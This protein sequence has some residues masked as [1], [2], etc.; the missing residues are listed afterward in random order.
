MELRRRTGG[1]SLLREVASPVIAVAFTAL[2][3]AGLFALLGKPPLSALH[4]YFIEPLSD[5]W[6]LHELAVKA[7]PLILIAVGLSACYRANVWNIGAEGQLVAGAIAGSAIPVLFPAATGPWLMPAMIVMAMAGGAAW[8]SIPAVL[9]NRFGASEILVSL[10]LVYVA[11]LLL[12]YLVRGPWRNPEGYNFPETRQ[13]PPSARI[14]EL[15]SAGDWGGRANWGIVIA[16]AI[17]VL[18]W[19]LLSRTLKGFE[20]SVSG[21]S[22]RA[23]R[24]AGFDARATA[25]FVFLFSG[26]LAGLAGM[27]EV[28]GAIG[29]LRPSISPGYGF[30]AIIV[31]F[32]GRLNPLAVILAGLLLALTYLGGEAA[33]MSLGLSDRTT[34]VFQGVLL[35]SVLA[36]ETLVRY[37]IR[38]VRNR[39]ADAALPEAA[40]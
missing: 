18:T 30:A 22:P 13:F 32:L 38:I 2:V 31:A 17:A 28:S 37:Q 21:A 10:M 24:F 29:Q 19:L 20:I 14:G 3:G 8:A 4:A 9:K 34:R 15:F 25:L 16:I 12:D 33:Q 36:S 40:R 39:P 27:I 23:A 35:F 11:E 1:A 7:A 26:A 6:S 5:I